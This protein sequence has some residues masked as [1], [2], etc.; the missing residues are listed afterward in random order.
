MHIWQAN[1]LTWINGCRS[2]VPC[3]RWIY[4]RHLAI[5]I[6]C[7]ITTCITTAI[8][9]QQRCLR[10]RT[11]VGCIGHVAVII[12]PALHLTRVRKVSRISVKKKSINTHS[13]SNHF[14]LLA[15]F[16]IQIRFSKVWSNDG[17]EFFLFACG[18]YLYCVAASGPITLPVVLYVVPSGM[19]VIM[20]LP[21]TVVCA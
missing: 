12:L 11:I 20:L 4:T 5:W 1:I 14:V 8:S 6:I 18:A 15:A 9:Q 7:G 17:K 10:R 19:C 13:F 2:T 16:F 21:S 3:Q